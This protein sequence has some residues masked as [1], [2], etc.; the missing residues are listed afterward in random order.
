ML[1]TLLF[2]VKI[3]K[4]YFQA[5]TYIYGNLKTTCRFFD[6]SQFLIFLYLIKLNLI[7]LNAV[8]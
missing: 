7:G 5:I 8:E 6:V 4:A 3:K 2:R 1:V